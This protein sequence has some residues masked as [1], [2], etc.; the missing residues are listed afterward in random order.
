MLTVE[1]AMLPP[2]SPASGPHET[3]AGKIARYAA[4]MAGGAVFPPVRLVR[5]DDCLMIIDGHHR[6]AAGRVAGVPVAAMIADGEAFE[7][8]DIALRDADAGRADDA[9]NWP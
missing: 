1:R 9:A 8:L 4:A 2:D 6:V 5:Y 7:D 3:D